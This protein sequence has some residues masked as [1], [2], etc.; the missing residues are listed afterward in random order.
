MKGGEICAVKT[1]L[2]S[3][4]PSQAQNKKCL[5][6]VPTF[7]DAYCKL[8]CV[9]DWIQLSLAAGGIPRSVLYSM[10]C[11]IAISHHTPNTVYPPPIPWTLDPL[12]NP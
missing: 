5:K 6:Q 4:T 1:E 11:P 12:S 9:G 8:D 3:V 7:V 10:Q 2:R